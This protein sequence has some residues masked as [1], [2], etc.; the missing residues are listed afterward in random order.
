M[1][2]RNREIAR[3]SKNQLSHDVDLPRNQ[4][5]RKGKREEIYEIPVDSSYFEH[6][7]NYVLPPQER[8]YIEGRTWTI[9]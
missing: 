4:H 9:R 2:K 6:R 5:M 3:I 1:G 8:T 7:S